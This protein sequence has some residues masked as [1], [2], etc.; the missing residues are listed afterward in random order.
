MRAK[1]GKLAFVLA[2]LVLQG[3]A[4][5]VERGDPRLM[6][7]KGRNPRRLPQHLMVDFDRFDF[8]AQTFPSLFEPRPPQPHFL[9]YGDDL[10]ITRQG[11]R[12]KITFGDPSAGPL[13]GLRVWHSLR[14]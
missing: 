2:D 11:I 10:L 1:S 13:T 12:G 5:I 4:L 6:F 3:A 7:R 14:Q 9:Q 8:Y